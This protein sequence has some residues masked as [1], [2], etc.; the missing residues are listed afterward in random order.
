[1]PCGR[2]AGFVREKHE[3]RM[4]IL[5]QI[6]HLKIHEYWECAIRNEL[7]EDLYKKQRFNSYP[8][9]NPILRMRE[10]F[11][12]GRTEPGYMYLNSII[13]NFGNQYTIKYLDFT[14]LY[15][16][17]QTGDYPIGHPEQIVIEKENR[18]VYWTHPKQ[19][20]YNGFIK[21]IVL[22]PHRL[23]TSPPV[24]P[25]KVDDRLLFP[26]CYKCACIYKDGGVK[27]ENYHCRHTPKQREFLW[28]GTTPELAEALK[29]GYVV[30]EVLFY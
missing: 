17:T 4:A 8:L 21:V 16:Y 22:P 14:S 5:N 10:G 2:A 7:A 3:K 26:L 30:T 25:L 9:A 27:E 23:L 6:P 19:I 28:T 12:G 1:M 15:P 13:N 20:P 29:V 18:N 11:V 24:L